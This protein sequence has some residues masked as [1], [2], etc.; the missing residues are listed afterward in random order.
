MLGLFPAP[1]L[2]G[3]VYKACGGGDNRWGLVALQL[4]GL[5]SVIFL[6]PT[7]ICKRFRDNKKIDEYIVNQNKEKEE[8]IL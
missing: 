1:S 2:Y 4:F 5:A 8:V 3:F 6:L 7:T